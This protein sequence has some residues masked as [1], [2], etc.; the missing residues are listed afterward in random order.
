MQ[1]KFS[2]FQ[3]VLLPQSC[4]LYLLQSLWAH[5]WSSS[6]S[7]RIPMAALLQLRLLT[8][9]FY[10]STSSLLVWADS[11]FTDKWISKAVNLQ[12]E[13]KPVRRYERV[14]FE[15]LHNLVFPRN[16]VFVFVCILAIFFSVHHFL[17]QR[18]TNG[19]DYVRGIHLVLEETFTIKDQASVHLN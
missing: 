9:T 2:I 11:S 18:K 19:I 4:L 8:F 7:L 15:K 17:F 5:L 12:R 14:Y 6:I 16:I 13:I 3:N 10:L 1:V